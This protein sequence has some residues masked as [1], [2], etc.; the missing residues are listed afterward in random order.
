VDV[1]V[2]D[3]VVHEVSVSVE[4]CVKEV[5]VWYVELEVVD[6]LRTEV[7]VEEVLVVELA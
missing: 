2:A 5:E 7:T 1:D 3:R 4:V 6:V